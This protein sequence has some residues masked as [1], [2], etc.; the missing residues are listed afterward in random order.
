M[1][2]PRERVL[3]AVSQALADVRGRERALPPV[4]DLAESLR[5]PQAS[6][7]RFALELT[8]LSG[9]CALVADDLTCAAAVS[10]YLRG[11]NVQSVAVQSRPLAQEI[12][13]RLS[14][15]DVTSAAAHHKTELEGFDC[16][17]LQAESLLADTGSAIV[18][19]DNASDRVLPYLPRTCVIVAGLSALHATMDL[20][21]VACI[22]QAA[23]NHTPGEALIVAGPS[24][25]ADI[26][27]TLVLGAHGPQNL[28]V[29]II[30]N[31]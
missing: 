20:S 28:G 18:I 1:T 23:A 11:R 5:N 21:S 10:D 2:E 15:F 12:G 25:T 30:Q 26:E 4:F 14:G 9:T 24:R 6:A 19:V 29:F 7:E 22:Q 27:K 8:A 13:S 17:L 3:A 16:S 31:V